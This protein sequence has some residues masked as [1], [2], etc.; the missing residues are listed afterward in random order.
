MKS[1]SEGSGY[2]ELLR[3]SQKF[4]R[5][6]HEN[7]QKEQQQARQRKK[8]QDVLGGLKELNISMALT[9]LKPIA[10]PEIITKVNSLKKNTETDEL[11]RLISD[12]AYDME[13]RISTLSV[14]NPDVK[15]LERPMKTLSILTEL[16]FSLK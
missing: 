11:R 16:F 2:E 6:E 15:P 10:S 4:K 7:T 3:L 9:Q 12:M 1:K 5:Q 8:V 13:K 14:S